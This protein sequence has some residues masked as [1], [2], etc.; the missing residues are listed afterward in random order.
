MVTS[1]SRKLPRPSL[2]ADTEPSHAADC[3]Q[4]IS[5]GTNTLML[6][7]I[8]DRLPSPESIRQ[9]KP[10]TVVLILIA[11]L[12]AATI[13]LTLR[14]AAH[15]TDASPAAPESGQIAHA[16]EST[17]AARV[18]DERPIVPDTTPA[19][20]SLPQ[21]AAAEQPVSEAVSTESK[22]DSP[23]AQA[24][25]GD[26]ARSTGAARHGSST[27]S[28]HV[29]SPPRQD[30]DVDLLAALIAQLPPPDSASSKAGNGKSPDT[31]PP[32]DTSAGQSCRQALCAGR[33]GTDP[34]CPSSQ[35]GTSAAP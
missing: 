8:D 6:S 34:A 16:E 29:Q 7:N 14:P 23:S 3:V 25:T 18:I 12:V 5:G 13:W 30:R 31:C 1:S 19:P 2:Y 27:H 21:A 9:W 35:Q 24:S 20:A 28:R 11:L 26:S 4:P 33:W 15:S 32:S 17:G 22:Q 10:G